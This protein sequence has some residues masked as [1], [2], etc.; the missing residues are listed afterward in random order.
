M[1]VGDFDTN[2]IDYIDE[3]YSQW[4]GAVIQGAT[5]IG[6]GIASASQT[7]QANKTELERDLKAQCGKRPLLKKN[8]P[9][10]QSC[11]DK[12]TSEIKAQQDAQLNLQKSTQ[13]TNAQ[14]QQTQIESDKLMQ[15]ERQKT[16]RLIIG[17]I[18]GGVA[19]IGIFF[20]LA[21]RK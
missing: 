9:T 13:Q 8:R 17:G 6:S 15:Q 18:L 16:N 21:K 12:V 20:I 14:I 2:D 7:A 10:W 5:A 11:I 3:D 1:Q 4:V 19:V